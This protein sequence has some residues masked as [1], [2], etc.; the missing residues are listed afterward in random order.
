[1][2]LEPIDLGNGILLFKNVL[3][4]P[5]KTYQF[6]LDSKTN[7]DPYFG[8]ASDV[9]CVHAY[10]MLISDIN[11]YTQALEQNHYNRNFVLG[12]LK[13]AVARDSN[14]NIVYEL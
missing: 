14:F 2:E 4:D 11:T 8:K 3:K 12:P 9:T 5:K 6:I 10:G 7:D 1:M 13:V